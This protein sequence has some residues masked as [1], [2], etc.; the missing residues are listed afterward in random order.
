MAENGRPIDEGDPSAEGLKPG[1]EV[2]PR[3]NLL[4]GFHRVVLVW[5]LLGFLTNK[6]I[7][8]LFKT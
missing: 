6:N 2:S 5:D 8:V 4:D 3:T 1:T 7:Y